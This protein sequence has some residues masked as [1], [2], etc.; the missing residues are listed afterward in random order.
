MQGRLQAKEKTL[1]NPWFED[2]IFIILKILK[3][4]D[5]QQKILKWK[6]KQEERR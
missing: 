5:F 1:F 4:Y 2:N 6:Q 3:N